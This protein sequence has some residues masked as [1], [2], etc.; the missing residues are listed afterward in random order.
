M[1]RL[2]MKAWDAI[3]GA[4]GTCVAVID[5]NMEEMMYLKD[6]DAK[7]SK[8]KTELPVLGQKGKKHKSGGWKG[9]GKATIYYATSL[10]RE[11]MLKYCKTGRDF[12]FDII[13]ENYDP[14]SDIGTQ[15][16]ILKQVNIDDI[17]VAKLDIG[18]EALDEEISFTFN[19]WDLEKSFIPVVG[20]FGELHE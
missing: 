18:T 8:E 5:G 12:Y 1:Q 19:S 13:V 2:S 16:T 11:K 3:H 20:E 15:R 4:E 14:A 17:N 9:T 7:I 6:L 10:F